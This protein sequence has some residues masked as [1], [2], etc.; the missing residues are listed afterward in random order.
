MSQIQNIKFPK[1]MEY[2]KTLDKVFM[3]ILDNPL[4]P[5]LYQIRNSLTKENVL[6]GIGKNAAIRM[7]SLLPKENGGKGTRNNNDKRQ[8]CWENIENLEIEVIY[9]DS[10]EEA[11]AVEDVLRQQKNHIFN[12]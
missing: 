1:P 8:Y 11:K 5:V 4:K 12:T 3:E 10:R 7:G 9:F 2:G 6:F